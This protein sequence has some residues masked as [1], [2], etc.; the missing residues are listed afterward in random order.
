MKKILLTFVLLAGIV[1]A[2]LAQKATGTA[3]SDAAEKAKR[4]QKLLNLNDDQT[5]R[6]SAIYEEA[7][8]KFDVIKVKERGN[9]DRML[10]V[11]RPLIK[12]TNIKIKNVLQPRQ[13]VEY[14]KLVQQNALGD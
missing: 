12:E 11:S 7:Y 3:K 10:A 9:T 13:A 4:L 6:V 8:A 2:G 5:A 14:D 1:V